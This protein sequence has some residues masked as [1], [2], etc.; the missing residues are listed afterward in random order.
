MTDAPRPAHATPRRRLARAATILLGLL[1][2][3]TAALALWAYFDRRGCNAE[4]PAIF[5]RF[6]TIESV[7]MAP[8]ILKGDLIWPQR[9]YFCDHDPRRGD[10]A[11]LMVPTESRAVFVKRIIGLPGDR[12][13][14]KAAVPYIDGEP[15][16]REWMDSA[17][18]AEDGGEAQG[19]SH[20]I[21]SFPNG[22]RYTVEIADPEGPLENTEEITVPDGAY[23][24]MG[25]NRDKSD[26]SRQSQTFGLVPRALIVD[27]PIRL[28]WGADWN[29]VALKLQ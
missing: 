10:L 28:L 6:Y 24:V 1:L 16:A 8:T 11:V 2:S 14:L 13:Q 12:V 7:S 18:H 29:R 23:F 19:V 4:T 17:I 25:D 15:V 21:E 9:R 3:V 5:S 22:P 26:D 27:R 20:F